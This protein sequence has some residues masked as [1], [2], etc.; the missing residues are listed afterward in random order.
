MTQNDLNIVRLHESQKKTQQP[1]EFELV[2]QTIFPHE[3]VGLGTRV[4]I[5]VHLDNKSA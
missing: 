4:Y 2:L 1:K 3:T 5:I